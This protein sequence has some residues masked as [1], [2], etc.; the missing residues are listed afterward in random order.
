[1][2]SL[3]VKNTK[4]KIN[5]ADSLIRRMEGI[6]ERISEVEDRTIE[7]IQSKQLK[8]NEQS[9]RNLW[10]YNKRSNVCH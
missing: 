10:D 8:E 9:L 7:M 6:G 2:E 1:M 3:E 5:S 4:T